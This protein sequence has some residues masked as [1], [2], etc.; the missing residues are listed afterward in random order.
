MMVSAIAIDTTGV[1]MAI[2]NSMKLQA[3]TMTHRYDRNKN[4]YG[5]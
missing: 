1:S 5:H 2:A 4:C 3:P